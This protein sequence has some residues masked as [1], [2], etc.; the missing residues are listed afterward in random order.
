MG[1]KPNVLLVLVDDMGY[2]DFGVFGDGTP[3][4]PY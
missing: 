1:R 4:T 2:G 3:Q